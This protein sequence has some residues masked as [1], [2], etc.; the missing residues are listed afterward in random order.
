[1]LNFDMVERELSPKPFPR[2]IV[3]I[4]GKSYNIND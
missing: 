2:M 3:V 1:M 4:F